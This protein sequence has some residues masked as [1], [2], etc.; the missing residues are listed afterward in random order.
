[1]NKID[2]VNSELAK[3]IALIIENK[4]KHPM[5]DGFVSVSSVETGK[6]L[7]L[8]KVRITSIGSTHST[9]EIAKALNHSAGFIRVQL[10]NKINIRKIPELMF[11]SDSNLEYAFKISKII[12]DSKTTKE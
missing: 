12:E 5:I 1:M 9:D 11:V 10:K 6:D 8:A 7:S 3:Q 4:I 2:R